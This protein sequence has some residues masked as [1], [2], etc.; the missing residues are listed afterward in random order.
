MTMSGL[1]PMRVAKARCRDLLFA[2]SAVACAATAL[3]QTELPPRSTSNDRAATSDDLT[4]L[5]M[6]ALIQRLPPA[7]L[8]FRLDGESGKFSEDPASVEMR[9]RVV[10]VNLT[11]QQWRNALFGTGAIR[12]RDRWPRNAEY[13]V[14]MTLPRWLGIAQIRVK[15]RLAALRERSVGILYLAICGNGLMAE[16]ELARRGNPMG[17]VPDEEMK[18]VFDVEVERG[19]SEDDRRYDKEKYGTPGILWKGVVT[20]PL[21]IVERPDEV[22]PCATNAELRAAIHDSIVAGVSW[23]GNAEVAIDPDLVK[24]PF[25]ERVALDL[26]VELLAEGK[27]LAET[28]LVATDVDTA[29]LN[30]SR[31]KAKTKYFGHGV[32]KVEQKTNDTSKWYLRITGQSKNYAAFWNAD[33]RW[34]GSF[35]MMWDDAVRNETCRA[36]S[37]GPRPHWLWG[38]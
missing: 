14:S 38:E 34:D 27:L 35:E 9:R 11:D 32:L 5:D 33:R 15:P 8:E 4:Q 18:L 10:T 3:G 13:S 29:A 31:C 7:G 25:L 22:L 6:D 16:R 1:L 23:F 21:Q 36:G 20:R 37:R 24:Y 12:F 26:R 30:A 17:T 19:Q 28:S 2:I